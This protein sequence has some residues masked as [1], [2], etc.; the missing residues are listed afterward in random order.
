MSDKKVTQ[1]TEL[2]TSAAEDLLLIIDGPNT[3]PVSKKI[4]IKNLFNA[5]PA[6][7]TFSANVT[8]SSSA[9][10]LSLQ[11]NTIVGTGKHLTTDSLILAKKAAPT[12][13]NA[14]N[15]TVTGLTF[16]P[17]S[18]IPVGTIWFNDTHL[19]IA[20]DATTIKRVALSLW[21]S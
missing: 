2:T 14:T 15:A 8:V 10:F 1:L 17:S 13:N 11:A 18:P 3:T 16:S 19:Y 12:T 5:V 6:N 21:D 4:S 7:T 9:N 20:T